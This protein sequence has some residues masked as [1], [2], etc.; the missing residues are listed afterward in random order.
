MAHELYTSKDFT[1]EEYERRNQ[2]ATMVID[3]GLAICKRCGAREIELD[4]YPTCADMEKHKREEREKC[5]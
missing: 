3:G 1:D 4:Q 2:L 5:L